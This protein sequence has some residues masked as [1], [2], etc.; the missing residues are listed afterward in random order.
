V[1]GSAHEAEFR[2]RAREEA[3]RLGRIEEY[4]YMV[5]RILEWRGIPV[6]A[7]TRGRVNACGSLDQL[8]TWAK[9]AVRATDAAEVFAAE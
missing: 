4:R 9:R 1:V 2:E 8:E 5:L 6:Y 7:D 3:R